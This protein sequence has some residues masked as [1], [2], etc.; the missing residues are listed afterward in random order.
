MKKQTIP[1]NAPMMRAGIGFTKPEAGVIAT[2]P[3][4]APE[5]PPNI[6]G[7]PSTIHSAKG[8]EWRAVHLIHAAD[9]N[10]PS[11]MALSD[12]DGLEE[13]RRLLYVALTRA[14][15]VLTVSMPQ[16]F[17]VRRHGTDDRHLLAGTLRDA[18]RPVVT[19]VDRRVN[20]HP[21]VRLALARDTATEAAGYVVAGVDVRKL[22]EEQ[23]SALPDYAVRIEVDGS[24]VASRIA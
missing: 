22:L 18:H 21:I 15:D 19:P 14:R 16:R 2:R 17:H 3:A 4:T 5:I 23:T 24:P 9:G 1:A 20:G 12:R 8:A 6:V 11:D 13:E 7:L 10:I